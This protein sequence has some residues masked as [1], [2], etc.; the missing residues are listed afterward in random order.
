MEEKGR[1]QELGPSCLAQRRLSQAR[2]VLWARIFPGKTPVGQK[3]LALYIPP[4][5][6]FGVKSTSDKGLTSGQIALSSS[7]HAPGRSQRLEGVRCPHSAQLGR[8]TYSQRG[9]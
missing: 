5:L 3:C 1:K 6:S 8:E 2:G 7:R 4:L 9:I